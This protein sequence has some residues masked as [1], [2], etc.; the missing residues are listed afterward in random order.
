MNVYS[1][2]AACLSH[3]KGREWLN[4][5]VLEEGIILKEYSGDIKILINYTDNVYR[6]SD[7]PVDALTATVIRERG[8]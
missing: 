8:Q 3:V 7:V 6:Y 1:E 2:A 4:R 5:T